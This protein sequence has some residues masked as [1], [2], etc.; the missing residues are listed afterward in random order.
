MLV[1]L[2]LLPCLASCDK[3][4]NSEIDLSTNYTDNNP[5]NSEID[6]SKCYTKIYDEASE[7]TNCVQILLEGGG[8]IIFELYPDIAPITVE[9]FKKL[10]SE[11]FYDGIIFH[12][13]IEDF[14]IQ[15]GDPD[16]TGLGGSDETIKGEFAVNG[17]ENSLSHVRGT[18]SMARR[19]DPY[20]DSASSQFFIVHEDSTSLDS[21]YA[22]FGSVIYGIETVDQIAAVSTNSSD[23]PLEDIII[24]SIYFIEKP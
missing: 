3:P 13:V 2:I 22:A 11:N 5:T 12:R 17:V 7:E 24:K 20:Y 10:V 23:K 8:T 4:T 21:S 6:L 16:G 1:A 9:N 15:T 19:G 14:M 18:V